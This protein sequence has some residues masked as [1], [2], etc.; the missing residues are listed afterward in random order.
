MFDARIFPSELESFRKI[1]NE[2]QAVLKGE[3]AIHDVI[4]ALKD[5]DQW[6]DKVFLRLR[7]VPKNIWDEK[8][9]VVAVKQTELKEVGKQ[10][11]IPVKKQFDTEEKARKFIEE[12]YADKFDFLYE[13][14]RTG[15]QYDMGTEQV[16]LEDIE[17]VY[18]I[19]FKSPTEDG[20]KN[21][22]TLFSV[23]DKDVIPGPSVVA[24]RDLL[25]R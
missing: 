1:L 22:L 21:L 15:W 23:A 14:D 10:S 9:F 6:I 19:E 11:V 17:G 13:F 25:D 18:S 20:L 5:S 7:L 8:P 3:Y 12:N 4:F 2:N 24:I 16:D